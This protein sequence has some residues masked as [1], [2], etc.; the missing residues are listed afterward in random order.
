M[1]LLLNPF[2]YVCWNW[3]QLFYISKHTHTHWTHFVPFISKYFDDIMNDTSVIFNLVRYI[4]YDF[5]IFILPLQVWEVK[6]HWS[7]RSLG[8]LVC[9]SLTWEV[10]FFYP[11]LQCLAHKHPMFN[12]NL[13]IAG[14][15]WE[16]FH[17]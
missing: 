14:N 4:E 6:D 10:C 9:A 8:K 13:I 7:P 5:S 15:H 3:F 2:I 11:S 17:F 1:R 12:G 16:I